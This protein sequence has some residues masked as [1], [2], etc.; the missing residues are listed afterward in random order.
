MH[1]LSTPAPTKHTAFVSH[2]TLFAPVAAL[3]LRRTVTQAHAAGFPSVAAWTDAIAAP[4]TAAAQY[5]QAVAV[6]ARRAVL[7]ACQHGRVPLTAGGVLI[8]TAESAVAEFLGCRMARFRRF[9]SNLLARFAAGTIPRTM[10]RALRLAARSAVASRAKQLAARVAAPM[11]RRTLSA[12]EIAF[13]N[14]RI[15]RFV[16]D[17]RAWG[18]RN[19]GNARAARAHVAA[20]E[21][22]RAEQIPA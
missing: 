18:A 2:S 20:L 13:V 16:A 1:L 5:R 9:A 22:W 6:E 17:A 12:V 14:A 4:P 7:A 15:D 3:A 21:A 10:R 19:A 11:P 8:L